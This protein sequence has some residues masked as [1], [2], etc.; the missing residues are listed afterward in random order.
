MTNEDILSGDWEKFEAWIREQVGGDFI[1]KV[2]PFDS[3]S[4]R[5]TVMESLLRTIKENDGTFPPKGNV[6]IELAS[7][8]G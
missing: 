8:N 2:R 4:N 7:H 3:R 6:F 1:W 5:Q